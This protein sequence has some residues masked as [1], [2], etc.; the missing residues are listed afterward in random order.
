MEL[1]F[2]KVS[3]TLDFERG[4]TKLAALLFTVFFALL[5]CQTFSLFFFLS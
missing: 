3:L 5:D 1:L 2:Q 4:E